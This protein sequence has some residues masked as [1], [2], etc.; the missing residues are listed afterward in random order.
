MARALRSFVASDLNRNGLPETDRQGLPAA[1][2]ARCTFPTVPQLLPILFN[3]VGVSKSTNQPRWR[4]FYLLL[5][6]RLIIGDLG[7]GVVNDAPAHQNRR[8]RPKIS[9]YR[10]S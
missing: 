1:L 4:R 10:L 5:Y 6:R 8:R 2:V 9:G 3:A 7:P